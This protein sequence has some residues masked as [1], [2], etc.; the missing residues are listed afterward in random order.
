MA[1]TLE[2]IGFKNFTTSDVSAGTAFDITT[3]ASTAFVIK[4]IL[5]KQGNSSNPVELKATL[6]AT[7]DIGTY[8][9]AV[10]TVASSAV[11]GMS[12]SLI[13]PPNHTFRVTPTVKT[14]AYWDMQFATWNHYQYGYFN[15]A[16]RNF[17]Q[18]SYNR[19]TVPTFGGVLE[20]T[21]KTTHYDNFAWNTS[22][23][24][25]WYSGDNFGNGS[26]TTSNYNNSY[27]WNENYGY[28]WMLL[29][30]PSL[31][32]SGTVGPNGG[33]NMIV[34]QGN[35]SYYNT[36]SW[37][38]AS[39]NS[40]NKLGTQGWNTQY[41]S[42]PHW[43]GEQLC[44]MGGSNNLYVRNIGIA[45]FLEYQG[46]SG[47]NYMT[48]QTSGSD[49]AQGTRNMSSYARTFWTNSSPTHGYWVTVSGHSNNNIKVTAQKVSKAGVIAAGQATSF[50]CDAGDFW[51]I[52]DSSTNSNNGNPKTLSNVYSNGNS[53]DKWMFADWHSTSSKLIIVIADANGEQLNF[54]AVDH[55]E[56]APNNARFL[57]VEQL[58]EFFGWKSPI[59]ET[60]N[61]VAR[62]ALGSGSSSSLTNNCTP[63]QPEGFTPHHTCRQTMYL[64]ENDLYLFCQANNGRILKYDLTSADGAVEV[65]ASKA[66][67]GAGT[68]DIVG[69][70]GNEQRET[71]HAIKTYP[72][73]SVINSRS[74]TQ[75]FSA[76]MSVYGIKETR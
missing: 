5:C 35:S 52:A 13:I 33:S 47:N 68:N 4:D 32:P 62:I 53:Y 64:A 42:Q 16:S 74:Y 24:S 67:S 59:I 57:T 70:D 54:L 11:S 51:S 3:D 71:F 15:N 27:Q 25:P 21:I 69:M 41:Y 23:G 49:S 2:K 7:S 20:K 19:T 48:I 60:S 39:D 10:G 8:P 14:A 22:T 66:K 9:V 31:N 37:A 72:T 61:G 46:T 12:G 58:D 17:N 28:Q 30:T 55:G 18:S 38:V 26:Y 29:T 44:F 34:G 45:G 6:A 65:I 1:D 43:D 76:H 73:T 75:G 50:T 56:R 36:Y 40:V 63:A